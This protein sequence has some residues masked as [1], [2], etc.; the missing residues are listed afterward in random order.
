MVCFTLTAALLPAKSRIA[1]WRSGGPHSRPGR[2]EEYV[3]LLSL[4]E[5]RLLLACPDRN[6]LTIPAYV[7]ILAICSH[8]LLSGPTCLC[9]DTEKR[10]ER[11]IVATTG[12]FILDTVY[13]AR[14][15]TEL[16]SQHR[17]IKKII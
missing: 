9:P 17:H 5:I 3:N 10:D 8:E 2:S 4:P 13:F 7:I 15:N 12:P 6:L 1:N 16:T 11:F 14:C